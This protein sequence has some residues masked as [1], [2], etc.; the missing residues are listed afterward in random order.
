[1]D[2]LAFVLRSSP[3]PAPAVDA[4]AFWLALQ[5]DLP[6]TADPIDR[7]V[8]G[9]FSSDRAGHAF[10]AGYQS[11]LSSLFGDPLSAELGSFCA[12]EKGGNRPRAIEATLENASGGRVLRGEKVWSSVATM[13]G[14]LFVVASAGVSAE[15][16]RKDLRVVR[17]AVHERGVRIEP[18]PPAPFIPEIGHARIVFDAVA[19]ADRDVLPGDGY[20]RYVKAFRTV[21][22]LHVHAAL[23]GYAIGVARRLAM[24]R[25]VV[26]ALC[27][28]VVGTVALARRSPVAPETHI[29]LAGALQ[30]NS[31]S[32][33]DLELH[34]ER[35][36]GDEW[37]RWQR[38]RA[39][40]E[41]AA[42]VR[43][44][45]LARAWSVLE[46]ITP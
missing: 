25:D 37:S 17:V 39:I 35:I 20:E 11:A 30:E 10:V 18:M 42:K 40:I 28:A 43:D 27:H 23:L 34:W 4:R 41:V 26:E 7:A 46:E 24:P 45:R 16:G 32:L 22:D 1:M 33:R 38:D 8:A 14:V 3:E 31:R 44:A 9:G 5:R 36:G 29:A 21:E 6:P 13:A 2:V 19:V 12:T 15:S